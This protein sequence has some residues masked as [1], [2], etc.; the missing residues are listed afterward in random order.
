MTQVTQ[1]EYLTLPHTF[2]ADLSGMVGIW[3]EFGRNGILVIT[4]PF[5]LGLRV[6]PTIF[7]PFRSDPN[8]TKILADS[9]QIP[10]KFRTQIHSDPLG[11]Y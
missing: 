5:L 7:R 4:E 6:I 10:S 2:W 11:L 1:P 8:P 3:L 9:Q